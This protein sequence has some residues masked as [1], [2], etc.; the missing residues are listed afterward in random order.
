MGKRLN[1]ERRREIEL[2]RELDA[3]YRKVAGGTPSPAP[4]GSGDRP[5]GRPAALRREKPSLRA[6]DGSA[7][8]REK[9]R[10]ILARTILWGILGAVL[11]LAILALF[12]RAA[13]DLRQALPEVGPDGPRKGYAIQIRAYPEAQ[14][15]QALAFLET[16]RRRHPD[17]R[18]ETVPTPDRGLRHRI[19]VGDFSSEGEAE[20][21]RLSRGVA[22]E[23]PFSFV[24]RASARGTHRRD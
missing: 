23:Y 6:G 5:S 7:S 17:A 9:R 12:H 21:N 14:S 11:F 2:E 24:Q 15:D 10:S 13:V 3:L 22:Q 18:I 8:R 1:P 19:L 20:E 16:I 4:P